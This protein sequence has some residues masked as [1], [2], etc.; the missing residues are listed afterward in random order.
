MSN[1]PNLREACELADLCST[2]P[3]DCCDVCGSFVPCAMS[4]PCGWCQKHPTEVVNTAA[5]N[6]CDDFAR[7]RKRCL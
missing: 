1:I 3:P 5:T 2:N 6:I 7:R 4:D